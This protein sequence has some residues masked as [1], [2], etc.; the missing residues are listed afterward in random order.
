MFEKQNGSLAKRHHVRLWLTS[1][2]YRGKPL[3]LGAATHDVGIA[4]RPRAF[5]FTHAVHAEIDQERSTITLDL[6]AAHYVDNVTL[7]DRSG[8]LLHTRN[9]TGDHLETDGRLA[10]IELQS[11]ESNATGKTGR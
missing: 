6:A 9:G 2:L 8:A 10:V 5:W 11:H 4:V 3:W 1:S 7:V